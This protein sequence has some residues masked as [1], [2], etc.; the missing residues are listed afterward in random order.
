MVGRKLKQL[1]TVQPDDNPNKLNTVWICNGSIFMKPVTISETEK[2]IA[3][4]DNKKAVG[5]DG[6]HAMLLKK[7]ADII[8]PADI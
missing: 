1:V 3:A 4:L 8:S 7:C 2:L 5:I 6:V